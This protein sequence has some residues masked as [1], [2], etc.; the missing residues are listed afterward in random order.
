MDLLSSAGD[1][2]PRLSCAIQ[3][4]DLLSSAGDENPRLSCAIQG[5]FVPVL[6]NPSSWERNLQGHCL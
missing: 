2:N 6:D 4:M 1:E 5:R 3:D